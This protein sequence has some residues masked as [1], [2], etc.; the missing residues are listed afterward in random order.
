MDT[1]KSSEH[2]L[3]G[4]SEIT[5]TIKDHQITDVQF[6][7]YTKT[8][9]LKDADYGNDK[10]SALQKKA[11]IAVTAMKSYAVQLKETQSIDGV[12]AITGA[13]VSYQQFVEAAM[14]AMAQAKRR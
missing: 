8:G 1:A 4:H 6:D 11:K 12:D 10:E 3:L 7:G 14:E 9:H 2:T 13:T 5:L